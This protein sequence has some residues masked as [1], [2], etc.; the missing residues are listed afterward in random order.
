[1]SFFDPITTP[2]ASAPLTGIAGEALVRAPTGLRRAENVRPG[3]LVVTQ[4]RGLQPVRLVWRRHITAEEMRADPG[5]APVRLEPRALGPMWPTRPLLLAPAHRVWV[6]PF[7]LADGAAGGGL[8]EARTL[9]GGSDAVWLDRDAE[10]VT[11]YNF[12]FD[13][14]EVV[15]ASGLPV[16]SFHVSARAVSEVDELTRHALTLRFPVLRQEQDAFPPAALP[17]A[18]EADYI[19]A[20]V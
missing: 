1:M 16:E 11:F 20:L 19:P 6:P 15:P 4:G 2:G 10:G 8:V 7:M 9:A 12:V 18:S 13:R 3:D 5:A 17:L 14:H